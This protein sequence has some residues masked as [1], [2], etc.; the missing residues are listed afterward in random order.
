MK[1]LTQFKKE[2]EEDKVWVVYDRN[3]IFINYF[4]TKD[5]ADAAAKEMNND[6]PSLKFHVKPMQRSEIEKK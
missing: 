6:T 3:D 2:I 5:E 1:T 4:Y